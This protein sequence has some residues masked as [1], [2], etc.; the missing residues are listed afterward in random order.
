MFPHNLSKYHH[1]KDLPSA[2][3]DIEKLPEETE[4]WLSYFPGTKP[5]FWGGDIYTS[6][7]IGLSIPFPKF[8]KK[9]SGW[10]KDKGYG[11]WPSTLL[12]MEKPV[13]LGWLLF[14]ALWWTSRSLKSAL[15]MWLMAFALENDQPWH[16]GPSEPW[17]ASEGFTYLC[18]WDGDLTCQTS[19]ESH[20]QADHAFPLKIQMH[21]APEMDCVL[22]TKEEK[23]G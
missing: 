14:S 3:D 5:C 12:Q 2:I 1:V 11:P 17:R 20:P 7:F 9:I 16:S 8:I 23:R 15:L 19:Y 10:C 4:E 22:N 21:L 18:W 13:S 6:I